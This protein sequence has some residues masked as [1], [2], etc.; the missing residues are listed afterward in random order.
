M[1]AY[2]LRRILYAIPVLLGVNL[3]TFALFFQVNTPEQMALSQLGAKHVSP[4]AIAQWKQ[5]RGYD[6]ALFYDQDQSGIARI[7]NTIFYEK[8]LR[9]F[10]FDFGKS[11]EGRSIAGEIQKRMWPSLAL[12]VPTLV[13]GIAVNICFALIIV[14]FRN[15]FFELFSMVLC[16]T[17]LSISAIFFIFAG[18]FLFGKVLNL[19][20]VSG[21]LHGADAFKFLVLPV[22]IGVISGV[23]ASTRVYR[24][25][26]LEEINRDYIRTARAKG[27]N[28][29][30]SDRNRGGDTH[31]V[32]GQPVNGKLFWHSGAG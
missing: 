5:D 16:I 30:N 22:L 20:P 7:T 4:E 32:Y 8:S 1:M 12:A 23:G 24:T 6:K 19:V 10:V 2:I 29:S 3:L 31:P 27:C 17:L 25:I 13:I 9:L 14:M 18:Q 11:D 21:Y 15:S 26:F 28:D